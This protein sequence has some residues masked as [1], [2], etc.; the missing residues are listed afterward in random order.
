MG[1]NLLCFSV[2]WTGDPTGFGLHLR[3]SGEHTHF[4]AIDGKQEAGHYHGDVTPEEIAY[5]GYF[6]PAT[7]VFRINDLES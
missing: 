3:S 4:F 2:L 7:M 1:P 5:S 6:H